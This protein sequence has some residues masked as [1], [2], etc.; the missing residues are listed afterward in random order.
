MSS[1]A[2]FNSTTTA[3]EVATAFKN[4]VAGKYFIITGANIGLGKESARV[5]AKEGGIITICSRTPS[6]GEEAKSDILKEFPSA[7][8]TVLKL[9]LGSLKSIKA[10]ADEY[11]NSKKP[12]NVLINN[13]GIMACPLTLTEDGFESQFGVNHV[14]HFYLTKLLLPLLEKS[15]T[16]K[17]PSRVVNLSS[18]AHIMLAPSEGILFDDLDGSKKYNSWTRYGNSKLANVLFTVD[19]QKRFNKGGKIAFVTL[20][21]G[22]ILSTNLSQFMGISSS[23]EMVCALNWRE[24]GLMVD[25]KNIPQGAATTIV[26][27][28]DPK[29]EF[30]K[31]YTDC[32]V[33]T[34]THKHA[35][36]EE[37]A[38]KL[39]KVTEELISAKI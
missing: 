25:Q 29:I 9:D 35:F 16:V 17:E 6:K 26:C 23:L 37:M 2:N 7:N 3:E 5:L 14:G 19:M 39:T 12:L 34:R 31:Y 27:A 36:D 22:N 24:A 33:S 11:S 20:H 21:P 38:E 18:I 8:I 32:Q 15:G 13:A 4:K 10:F 30:A 1:N 28:L